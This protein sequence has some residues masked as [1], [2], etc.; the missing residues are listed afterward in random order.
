MAPATQLTKTSL[1]WRFAFGAGFIGLAG[2]IVYSGPHFNEW[3]L[4]SL[5][6]VPVASGAVAAILGGVGGYIASRQPGAMSGGDGPG[7]P[8][9]PFAGLGDSGGA[10]DHFG[11]GDDG[12][13]E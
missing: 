1:L 9:G 4:S 7:D 12:G 5:I 2:G 6:L 13:H 11:G 3:T 8:M 10:H